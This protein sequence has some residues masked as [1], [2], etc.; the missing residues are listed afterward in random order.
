MKSLAMMLAVS[1]AIATSASAALADS[2]TT[3]TTVRTT[4]TGYTLP[5]GNSYVVVNPITG[6]IVGPYDTAVGL[7]NG[8]PVPIGTYVIEKTSGKV[9]ATVDASGSIIAFTT[10]PASLPTHFVVVNGDLLYCDS[11]YAARRAKIDAQINVEYAAGRLSNHDVKELREGLAEIASLEMKKKG[12]GTYSST[13]TN[14]IER[15]FSEVQSDLSKDI[16]EINS[17]RAKIGIKVD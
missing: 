7:V 14:R 6:S 5:S 13:T 15:R 11:D 3:T 16:S 12:N 9:L 17:K 10:V 4:T 2:E 1:L 8:Q